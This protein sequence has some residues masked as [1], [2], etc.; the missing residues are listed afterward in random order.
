MAAGTEA[1]SSWP[2][3]E[4]SSGSEAL[5]AQIQNWSRNLHQRRRWRCP[6]GWC[7]SCCLKKNSW[8]AAVRLTWPSPVHELKCK[9]RTGKQRGKRQISHTGS[10]TRGMLTPWH[11]R[12]S[13]GKKSEN[14]D[15]SFCFLPCFDRNKL[16]MQ[17]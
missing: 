14:V 15:Y 4:A 9:A 3:Y 12:P 2:R 7:T 10:L 11:S 16:D 17:N 13:W 6:W 5:P 1:S 8:P